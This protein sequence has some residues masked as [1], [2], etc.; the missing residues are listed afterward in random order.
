MENQL[1]LLLVGGTIVTGEGIH[2]ADVGVR[3]ETIAAVE[4]NL[5]REAA[6]EVIDVSGRYIFPGKA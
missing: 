6:R 4:P 2:R 3:G 1:D 5:A